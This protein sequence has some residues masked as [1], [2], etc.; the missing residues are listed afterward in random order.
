M[1]MASKKSV[2]AARPI[3]IDDFKKANEETR[4]VLAFLAAAG[5]RFGSRINLQKSHISKIAQNYMVVQLPRLKSIPKQVSDA[6]AVKCFCNCMKKE[7]TKGTDSV[8][9]AYCAM[10]AGKG[11]GEK[12]ILKFL[13]IKNPHALRKAQTT[14]A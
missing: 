4:A 5:M 6:N 8:E 11:E 14:Q 2:K 9:R 7:G 1:R 12:G 10:R 13:P 3:S